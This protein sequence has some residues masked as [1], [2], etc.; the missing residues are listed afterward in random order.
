MIELENCVLVRFSFGL[1][2]PQKKL[3]LSQFKKLINPFR[4]FLELAKNDCQTITQYV[5][6]GTLAIALTKGHISPLGKQPK[7][8]FIECPK[9][10]LSDE[11]Q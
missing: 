5:C 4:F 11:A 2:W 6:R 1:G 9:Q 8:I 10:W 3:L 7:S